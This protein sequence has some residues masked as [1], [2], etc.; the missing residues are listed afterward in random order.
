MYLRVMQGIA[1]IAAVSF[2]VGW[3]LSRA[4]G[5]NPTR[6]SPTRASPTRT[7]P[8]RTSEARS[9]QAGPAHIQPADCWEIRSLG[10]L[11]GELSRASDLNDSGQVVGTAAT[12]PRVLDPADP[13]VS[14]QK[15]FISAV[16][17]GALTE[18]L[19]PGYFGGSA[20]AINNA[21]QVV[22]ATTIGRSF[23]IAYMTDPGGSN[24]RTTL[25]YAVARD[26]NDLGQTLWDISYP[27]FKT[28]IGP[29][30]QPESSGTDLIDVAV[31]T[32]D[33]YR[34]FTES[35]ALNDDGQ[36]ALHANQMTQDPLVPST[37]PAAYLWSNAAGADQIAPDAVS[38]RV[39]DMNDAG[40][41]VG[42]LR[43]SEVGAPAVEQAFVTR[44]YLGSL[45]MLGQPG[46]GNQ[47]TGLNNL[48][49]IVGTRATHGESH[50]YVTVPVFVNREIDLSTLPEVTRES[51][52]QLQPAAI[53][54]RGQIAGTGLFNGAERAFILSPLSPMAFVP[55]SG[56]KHAT[57]YR[58][59]GQ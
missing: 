44:R 34:L 52:T 14:L 22:G 23:P 28:V 55:D 1:A 30:E 42:I 5:P 35:T 11:G 47:P 58:W 13:A 12:E 48:G 38:S 16:N 49:Q 39:T 19:V 25:A 17:G 43:T 18:I 20:T 21:G 2:P 46:D 56:G 54:N 4:E 32:A 8:A 45:V 6:V 9:D 31:P 33:S 41:V 53:N 15:P 26:I 37:E 59:N 57:C 3:D 36:V 7:T 40:Q 24:V 51:W 29:T 50:A 10:T 27:F